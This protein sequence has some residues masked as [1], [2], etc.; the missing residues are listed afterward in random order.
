MGAK[1][2]KT[3]MEAVVKVGFPQELQTV[4]GRMGMQAREIV[5]F[6]VA[7]EEKG[8]VEELQPVATSAEELQLVA[9]SAEELQ[10]MATSAEELQRLAMSAIL[11][12]RK[13]H[14]GQRRVLWRRNYKKRSHVAEE[15]RA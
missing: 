1:K 3:E 4:R 5:M 12:A 10:R 13:Q 6:R 11:P 2:T 8:A 14:G 15:T 9:T 7:S